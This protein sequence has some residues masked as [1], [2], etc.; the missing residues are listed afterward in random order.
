VVVEH[1][2]PERIQSQQFDHVGKTNM[3]QNVIHVVRCHIHTV[4]TYMYLIVVVEDF[5]I[6]ENSQTAPHQTLT[7]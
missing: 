4:Y 3:P 6:Q 5:K 1:S 2:L 7:A